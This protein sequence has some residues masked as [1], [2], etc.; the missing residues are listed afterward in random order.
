MINYD[1]I[2]EYIQEGHM[3]FEGWMNPLDAALIATALATQTNSNIRS[4][5][6]E[7]GVYKENS[8]N[9]YIF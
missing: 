7:V 9:F 8:L 2:N 3:L 4:Y 6:L 5:I 1:K